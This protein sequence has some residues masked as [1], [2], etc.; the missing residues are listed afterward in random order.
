MCKTKR[1]TKCTIGDVS[2]LSICDLFVHLNQITFELKIILHFMEYVKNSSSYETPDEMSKKKTV[3]EK[4][5]E[6]RHSN[7][8]KMMIKTIEEAIATG[9]EYALTHSF[10]Q[11]TFNGFGG[12]TTTR[13]ERYK[14][15]RPDSVLT[16]VFS[17]I[18]FD[19]KMWR[20]SHRGI[21]M[22]CLR[23]FPFS[24][25]KMNDNEG[26][27]SQSIGCRCPFCHLSFWEA[28][29]SAQVNKI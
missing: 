17:L 3:S 9:N 2:L 29:S 1:T 18:L 20:A 28:R 6:R 24:L 23:N 12:L 27:S 14:T 15:K 22:K 8:T 26:S 16:F 25:W 13:N 10:Q 5:D 7:T 19:R 4:N 21:S 11:A